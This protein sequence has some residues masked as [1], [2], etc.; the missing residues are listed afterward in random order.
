[1]FA[2]QNNVRPELDLPGLDVVVEP[3]S[4]GTAKFDLFFNLSPDETGRSVVGGVEYA[5]DLFD[6]STV[7]AIAACFARVVGQIVADPVKRI[8]PHAAV[9]VAGL[10][11][12]PDI[13]QRAARSQTREKRQLEVEF[14]VL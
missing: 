6:R 7:E 13:L 5:T 11:W 1:M 2:W 14:D 8:G 9:H 12:R 3:V 4:T 10:P